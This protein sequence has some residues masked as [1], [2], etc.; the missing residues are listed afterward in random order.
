MRNSEVNWQVETQGQIYEA[1]FEELKQWIVEG[2]V[3]SSDKVKRG[4]LRWLSVEKVP[5]LYQYFKSDDF[6]FAPSEV[7]AAH[8]VALSAKAVRE[9]STEEAVWEINGEKI[10]YLHQ[11]AEAV[12]A[13]CICK[14]MLC[15]ICPDSYGADVKLC[16]LCG[17][18]CRSADERLDERKSI[19][20]INKPYYKFDES[21][22]NSKSQ[23]RLQFRLVDLLKTFSNK[24]NGA[25]SF[26]SKLPSVVM[27]RLSKNLR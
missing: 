22:M 16:P 6:V 24:L 25:K 7:F 12:Y 5:E 8:S 4:D 19:G 20:A 14:K 2:A 26:F 10:C 1:D 15:K 21:L 18:L 13:C 9:D 17:S 11:D 27:S 3:L 23:N